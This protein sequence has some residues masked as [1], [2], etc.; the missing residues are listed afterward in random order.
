MKFLKMV[1]ATINEHNILI[2]QLS[3]M[4]IVLIIQI[5]LTI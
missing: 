2:Y 4:W 3:T 5:L 1:T